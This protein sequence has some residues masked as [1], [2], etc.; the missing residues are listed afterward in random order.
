MFIAVASPWENSKLRD[1]LLNRE[2][3]LS[4]AESCWVID[5]WRLDY[6]HHC[7]H[8]S[9]DYQTPAAYAT[10]CVLPASPTPQPPEHSHIT[11]S[12]CPTHLDENKVGVVSA[13]LKLTIII[14]LHWH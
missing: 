4:F 2:V 13:A 14:N 9:L 10:G 3:F 1:E 12:D 5:R 8:K 11:N 6:N 7:I